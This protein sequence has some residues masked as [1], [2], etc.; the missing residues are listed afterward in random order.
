MRI[1]VAGITAL[2][3]AACVPV[4]VKVW[5]RADHAP[6]VGD[7]VRVET[8]DGRREVMRVYRLDEVGF[9]GVTN[10][11]SR[12]RVLYKTVKNLWVRK[13]ET[14]W[15]AISPFFCCSPYY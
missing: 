7:V 1:L 9:A 11:E 12:Y 13:T 4:P 2:V 8:H 14:E 3:L 10:D 5:D 15:E 6:K